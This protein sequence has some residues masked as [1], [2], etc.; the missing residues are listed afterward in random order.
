MRLADD[1]VI[2]RPAGTD[3]YG[4]ANVFA[5]LDYGDGSYGAGNYGGND[6]A[7]TPAKAFIPG[8]LTAAFFPAGTDVRNADRLLWRGMTFDVSDV[9]TVRSPSR[10]VLVKCALTRIDP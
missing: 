8:R 7:E 2:V 9:A 3:E 5:P 4:N 10:D 1:V 6:P